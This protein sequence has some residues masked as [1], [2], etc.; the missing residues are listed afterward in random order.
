MLEALSLIAIFL[1]GLYGSLVRL[2]LSHD[3]LLLLLL[4]SANWI[5]LDARIAAKA[6]EVQAWSTLLNLLR[7]LK[8]PED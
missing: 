2:G 3:L 7:F 6:A 1:P 8:G 4:K 5:L